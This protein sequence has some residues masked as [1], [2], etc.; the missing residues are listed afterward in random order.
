ME[1]VLTALRA[2]AEPS[3][4]RL[5]A[6]LAR[7]E[8]TVS[9]LT[10]VMAQS[11]PRV[12]RHLKL[13][14]EAGLIDR[15][16]EGSWV[17]YRLADAGTSADPERQRVAALAAKL[18]EFVPADDPGLAADMRRLE[19]VRAQR[20]ERAAAYFK[21]NATDWNRIRALHLPE[22][23]VEQAMLELLGPGD[24]DQLIDIGTGTGRILELLGGR[25]GHGVGID[26]SHDM[27]T[28]ARAA[29][30]EAGLA[31]CQV[32]QGDLFALPFEAASADL[33]T[34]HQVLHYLDDPATAVREA[35]RVLAPGGRLLIVDFA[36]HEL[37]FLRE[38]HQHR[39]LGFADDEIEGWAKASGLEV[40]RT[41]HMP[42]EGKD[43]DHKLT[44]S[45]W[46][47]ARPGDTKRKAKGEAA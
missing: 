25:V 39:R 42:P 7:S 34:V 15:F 41:R 46:L 17:F 23:D 20:A 47:L 27:L 43:K 10:Q 21:A 28:L 4:L 32:R 33:V 36:P 44:V 13:L 3:R 9:E 6:L 8:L 2:A 29:L 11:Q 40:L 30:D 35:G 22:R 31:N 26:L 5:L 37:E 45:L 38:E 19:D 1:S 12:S 16:R 14:T 18:I 24:F